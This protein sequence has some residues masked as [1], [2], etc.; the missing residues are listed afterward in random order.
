MSALMDVTRLECQFG[1]RRLL[2]IRDWRLVAGRLVVLTGDNGSGKTTLLKAIAG[3]VRVNRLDM[4]LVGQPV[5]PNGLDTARRRSVLYAHQHPYLFRTSIADNIEYGLRQR[6]VAP[7][8]RRMAVED[9]MRWA[10][11]DAIALTPPA[12]LSGGEKQKV[13][14]A[15][16]KVLKPRVWL[17]D[18]PTSSLDR[19]TRKQVIELLQTASAGDDCVV[20]ACH[21][22]EIIDLP[23]TVRYHL[24]DGTLRQ[25][26]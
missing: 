15:R 11:L 17:I 14:L 12:K 23:D 3:L 22:R 25:I 19:H 4:Q 24:E 6:A 10:G 20:V 1:T 8:A 7:D 9:A 18:E 21:D 2:D 13:A 5:G 26:E 16:M